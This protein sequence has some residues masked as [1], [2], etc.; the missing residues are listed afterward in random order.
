[1]GALSSWAMLAL[2]HHLIVQISAIISGQG[3]ICKDYAL[4]GDDI[5]IWNKPL[6][7]SYLK[8]MK[9]LG[10]EINLSK[11]ILSTKGTG[12][13]FAKRTFMGKEDVSPIS[14]KELSAALK[15]SGSLVMFSRKYNL[16]TSQI[17]SL[18]GLGYKSSGKTTRLR[19]WEVIRDMPINSKEFC[20]LLDKA[21]ETPQTTIPSGIP[22]NLKMTLRLLTKLRFLSSKLENRINEN[23]KTLDS[24]TSQFSWR[25]FFQFK[26]EDWKTTRTTKLSMIL[27]RT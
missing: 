8:V 13:E 19:A 5:V 4:L 27:N 9:G 10:V 23:L 24:Y 15:S 3:I 21:L 18:L 14:L 16:T 2:T 26:N 6:A 17:K 12:L 11:S 1:M 22:D 7:L 20:M 25:R